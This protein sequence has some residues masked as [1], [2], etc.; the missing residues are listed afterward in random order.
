M[1]TVLKDDPELY[2]LLEPYLRK[3]TV[4]I[5]DNSVEYNLNEA[6]AYEAVT[7]EVVNAVDASSFPIFQNAGMDGKLY[8]GVI[9]NSQRIE[10]V[11]KYLKY[12]YNK[13]VS[14]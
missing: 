6:D 14:E 1:D 12:L 2:Q 4:I 3:G 8:I 11:C 5:E 9:G 13:D 10:N 7:E